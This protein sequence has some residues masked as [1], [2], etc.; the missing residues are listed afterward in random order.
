[1]ELETFEVFFSVWLIVGSLVTL[2]FFWDERQDRK[3][4]YKDQRR[5]LR[6]INNRIVGSTSM[7][8]DNIW[9]ACNLG[10]NHICKEIKK[11]GKK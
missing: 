5:K 4:F 1:M 8:K 6:E 10:A 9:D 11:N 2:W 3:T 7:L